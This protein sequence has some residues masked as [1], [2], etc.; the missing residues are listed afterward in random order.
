MTSNDKN[1]MATSKHPNHPFHFHYTN[2][3]DNNFKLTRRTLLP[4]LCLLLLLLTLLFL[5]SRW[6]HHRHR[7]RNA[8]TP[9]HHP[10]SS[11]VG[12]DKSTINSIPTRAHRRARDTEVQ[13]PI[14]LGDF[15]DGEAVKALPACAHAYHV[16]CVD[17]WLVARSSCPVCRASLDV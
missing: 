10:P 15:V 5:Y 8:T 6:V 4:V 2:F 9:N 16:E 3:D 12:L 14:C 13:C 17:Q 1:K 7:H 11:S